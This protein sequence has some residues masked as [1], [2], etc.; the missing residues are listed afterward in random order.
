MVRSSCGRFS[1]IRFIN[2]RNLV[3]VRAV[4][5]IC[6]RRLAMWDYSPRTAGK[7]VGEKRCGAGALCFD[8]TVW[9]TCGGVSPLAERLSVCSFRRVRI[10]LPFVGALHELVE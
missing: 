8:Y 2:S 4:V 9:V 1:C 10:R 5:A 3:S 6:W 7:L